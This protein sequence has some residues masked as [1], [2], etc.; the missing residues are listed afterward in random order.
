MKI[1]S[2]KSTVTIFFLFSLII[3]PAVYAGQNLQEKLNEYYVE[4]DAA[5]AKIAQ[6]GALRN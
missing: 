2:C 4:F 3:V 5:F 6:S 1:N